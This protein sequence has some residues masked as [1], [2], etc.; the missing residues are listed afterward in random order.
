MT[1]IVAIAIIVRRDAAQSRM[2]GAFIEPSD[3]R[4][5]CGGFGKNGRCALADARDR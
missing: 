5:E 2:M 3:A 4:R 1:I